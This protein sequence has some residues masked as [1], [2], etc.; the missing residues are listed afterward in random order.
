MSE[1]KRWIVLADDGRHV[2][3]GRHTDPSEE[4]IEGAAKALSATGAGGWLAVTE[5]RYYSGRPALGV[6]MVRELAP[7]KATWDE[8]VA[9]FLRLRR[10]AN[11]PSR[12]PEEPA[13]PA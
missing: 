4:E 10:D 3:I 12:R 1:E 7:P 9:A 5:G 11:I 8:A 2:T 13:G 6:L